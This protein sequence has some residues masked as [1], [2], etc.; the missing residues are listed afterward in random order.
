[1]KNLRKVLLVGLLPIALAQE[2]GGAQTGGSEEV[3]NVSTVSETFGLFTM[4]LAQA[5]AQA[6]V[7]NIQGWQARLEA[8]GRRAAR[9]LV[10]TSWEASPRRCKPP[11]PT[12]PPSPNSSSV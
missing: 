12:P 5:S 6:A 4:G 9:E 1:M 8:T 11:R 10:R 7:Q 2:T 3:Y